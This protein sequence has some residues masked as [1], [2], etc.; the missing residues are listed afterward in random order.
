[1][2][3]QLKG[4]LTTAGY[5]VWY[6]A[7]LFFAYLMLLI[8]LQYIPAT[9]DAAFLITKQNV[10][11]HLYY[12]IAFFAHVYT[13][14]FVLLSGMLQFLPYV[15]RRYPL[16]HKWSGRLYAGLILFVT[17][18]AG[19]IMGI[20]GNGGWTAQLA[21]CVLAVLWIWF[22]WKAVMLAMQ[23]NF[24]AH[25]KWMYRSYALTLSA[26]SLRLWRWGL[27]LILQPRPMDIYRVV[28]WLGWG[29]NLLIAEVLIIFIL[30]KKTHRIKPA[31]SKSRAEAA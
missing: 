18:P 14:M 13:G 24:A 10:V 3:I 11:G 7:L 1:M 12:R 9:R 22:T 29:G 20:Y 15:R 6:A 4:K 27:V 2:Q 19:F 25:K 31:I 21:F 28:A 17:G 8:T 5:T 30:R 26:I 23:R 16:L